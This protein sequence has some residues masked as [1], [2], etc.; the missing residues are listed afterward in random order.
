VFD[1]EAIRSRVFADMVRLCRLPAWKEWAWTEVKRMDEDGLFKGIK[2]HVL[3][4][5]KNAKSAAN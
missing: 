4:E 5:M 2:A 1:Q 3:G